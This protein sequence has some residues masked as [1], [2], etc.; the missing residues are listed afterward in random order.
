V[1]EKYSA[2]FTSSMSAGPRQ[3]EKKMLIAITVFIA[4]CVRFFFY[5][6]KYSNTCLLLSCLTR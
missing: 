2:C 4:T 5:V 1:A 3:D 6:V